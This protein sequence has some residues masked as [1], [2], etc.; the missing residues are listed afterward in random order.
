MA[1]TRE[2]LLLILRVGQDLV[3]TLRS[4][5]RLDFDTRCRFVTHNS[6][7]PNRANICGRPDLSSDLRVIRRHR[8]TLA[9][10]KEVTQN[11][12]LGLALRTVFVVK[13][14]IDWWR[15]RPVEDRPAYP[16]LR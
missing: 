16:W 9:L 2:A 8:T 13:E 10:D 1:M 12:Y 5:E 7:T 11:T 4:S 14:A 6:C 15:T 3:N